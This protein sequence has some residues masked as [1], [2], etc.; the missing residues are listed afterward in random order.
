MPERTYS[1]VINENEVSIAVE[2]LL[3]AP[4]GTSYSPTK[5]SYDVTA[6][7]T[8]FRSLGAVVDDSVTLTITREKFQLMTGLPK[9][10][11][12][13][14]VIGMS[15]RMQA[16]LHSFSPR[17]AQYAL[18]NFDP[19]NT[20]INTS[21]GISS[22]T[23]HNVLSLSHTNQLAVGDMVVYHPSSATSL[24]IGQS[25]AEIVSI[26]SNLVY[27]A[28]PG[29]DVLPTTA[30]FVAKYTAVK[31]A[32]GTSRITRYAMI[33]LADLLDGSQI[34]HYVPKVA[35]GAEFTEAIKH[36]ENWRMPVSFDIYSQLTAGFGPTSEQVLVQRWYFPPQP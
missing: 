20:L 27:F 17:K 8:G 2:H 16:V 34:Q 6:W 14:A 5:L 24:P 22:V 26:S 18:G 21:S 1:N 25:E 4:V 36:V 30:G 15:G 7:P 3:I 9:V 10:L 28:T 32:I 11:Q 19:V 12:Y 31:Q 13:E 23:N 35:P 33:G 29:F